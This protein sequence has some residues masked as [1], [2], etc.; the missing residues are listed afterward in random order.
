MQGYNLT[1]FSTFGATGAATKCRS[2]R[3][4]IRNQNQRT[5]Q[6]DSWCDLA[7]HSESTKST[8]PVLQIHF[9]ELVPTLVR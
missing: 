7:V 2:R 9:G 5:G 4:L 1:C 6:H 3:R 8:G